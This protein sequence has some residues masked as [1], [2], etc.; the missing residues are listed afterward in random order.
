[1]TRTLGQTVVIE[2]K[3]GA[4]GTIAAN[5]VAKAQ[6]DGYTIFIHH[7]GMATATA[8]YRKLPYNVVRDFQPIARLSDAPNI[9]AVHPSFPA[10]TVPEFIAYARANPGKVNMASEGIGASAHVSGEL[11]N[12]GNHAVVD[13]A[14]MGAVEYRGPAVA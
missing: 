8:L 3:L 14:H 1:M 11:F 9:L 7:N 13:V 12:T 5:Y 4:G 10:K 2:N 6:P